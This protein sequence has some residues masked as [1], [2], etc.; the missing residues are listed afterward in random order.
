MELSEL[1]KLIP[2]RKRSPIKLY[3]RPSYKRYYN[4]FPHAIRITISSGGSNI[5]LMSEQKIQSNKIKDALGKYLH[6]DDY[7]VRH[8]WY[9]YNIFCKDLKEA[10]TAIKPVLGQHVKQIV[11]EQMA[12]DVLEVSS[13]KPALPKAL[14][15]VVKKLPHDIYRYRVFWPSTANK[16]A[17]IGLHSL[18]AITA[19]INSSPDCRPIKNKVVAQIHKMGY[20]WH[21]RYF[22][23]N[24]EDIFSII[25][26]ID[27]RFI[28]RIEKFVTLEELNAEKSS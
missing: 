18:E 16:M 25:S 3:C 26:L 15:V 19:Q 22:Y 7:K 14:T 24:N 17:A 2:D 5:N 28:I 23:A 27:P 13:Q 1:T 12:D 8:E 20:Q 9:H 10:L 4:Q 21:A 6:P 11:I